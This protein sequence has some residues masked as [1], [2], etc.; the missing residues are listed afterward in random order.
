MSIT[1]TPTVKHIVQIKDTLQ[2]KKQSTRI[3]IVEVR[4]AQM[5]MPK[6]MTR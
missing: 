5:E 2:I 6:K 4:A 3:L 1:D